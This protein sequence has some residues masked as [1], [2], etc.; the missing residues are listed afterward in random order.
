M[1]EK[2]TFSGQPSTRRRL[3]ASARTSGNAAPTDLADS[4]RD[5]SKNEISARENLD[6][7]EEPKEEPQKPYRQILLNELNTGLEEVQAPR[8][9]ASCFRLSPAGWMSA[10]VAVDGGDAIARVARFLT[11]HHVTLGGEHVCDRIHFRRR[12][13]DR[14]YLPSTP[15][16]AMF[17][18]I[19]GYTGWAAP[20]PGCGAW[21]ISATLLEWIAFS[22][23]LAFAEAIAESG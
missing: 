3:A 1:T 4:N 8:R 21:F 2:S 23:L 9:W 15:P 11:S 18:V 22:A 20:G 10:L 19:S 14:N 12:R 6:V 5:A 13:G 7:P 17:P 16:G